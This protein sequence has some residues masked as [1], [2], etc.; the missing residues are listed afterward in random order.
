MCIGN[1]II[2]FF[3]SQV[4]VLLGFI[5]FAIRLVMAIPAIDIGM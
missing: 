1:M 2:E 3:D 5:S 4:S